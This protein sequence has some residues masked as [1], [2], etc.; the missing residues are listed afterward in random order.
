MATIDLNDP[1]WGGYIPWFFRVGEFAATGNYFLFF[2]RLSQRFDRLFAYNEPGI[3]NLQ[4]FGDLLETESL[5]RFRHDRNKAFF[6][7]S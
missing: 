5:Q 6:L 1:R 7:S 3:Q 2:E 4:H